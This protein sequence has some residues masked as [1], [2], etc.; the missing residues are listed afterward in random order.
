M[1]YI[2]VLLFVV[3]S[4]FAKA[5]VVF[6]TKFSKDAQLKVCVV[7]YASDADL[8][9]FQTKFKSEVG[10]N[11]GVWY[12]SE[13]GSDVKKKIFITPFCSDADLKIFYTKFPSKAGWLNKAKMKLME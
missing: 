3:I 1:K 11:N 4:F 9:V 6:N 13:F 10:N 5:Q 7:K 2:L 8:I 12:F